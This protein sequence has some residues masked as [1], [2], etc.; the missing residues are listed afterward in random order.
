M[1]VLQ[2]KEQWHTTSVFIFASTALGLLGGYA[3]LGQ[4]RLRAP[5]PDHVSAVDGRISQGRAAL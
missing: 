1:K 4:T 5:A 3:E 2:S